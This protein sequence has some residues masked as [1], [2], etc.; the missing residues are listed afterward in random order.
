MPNKRIRITG[1]SLCVFLG[2]LAGC[3]EGQVQ[4]AG[5][6]TAQPA[7]FARCAGSYEPQKCE[8]QE[9]ALQR[10]SQENARSRASSLDDERRKNMELANAL[11]LNT[12]V[13]GDSR[14]YVFDTNKRNCLRSETSPA[15]RMRIIQGDGYFAKSKELRNGAVEVGH[16]APGGYEYWWTYFRSQTA[17]QA[18]LPRSQGVPQ[19]FE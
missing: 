19:K 8:K 15:D 5:G 14:W 10:E 16:D 12:E 9:E 2:L 6:K 13:E 17:C 3:S 4:G 1:P 18:A 7:R 11:P